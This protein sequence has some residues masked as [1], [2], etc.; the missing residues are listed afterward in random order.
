MSHD[1]IEPQLT[2]L[3][4]DR[5]WETTQAPLLTGVPEDAQD[6]MRARNEALAAED[7]ELRRKIRVWLDE[8]GGDD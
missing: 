4:A 1:Y 6:S 5:W 7:P 2:E 8:E 3:E